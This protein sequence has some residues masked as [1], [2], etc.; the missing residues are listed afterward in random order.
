MPMTDRI[1]EEHFPI[2]EKL[3]Q[4]FFETQKLLTPRYICRN[5]T[6]VG[7][8]VYCDKAE[9][10]LNM[11][12]GHR[13][14]IERDGSYFNTLNVHRSPEKFLCYAYVLSFTKVLSPFVKYRSNAVVP[15]MI[16]YTF[17][18]DIMFNQFPSCKMYTFFI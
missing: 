8:N 17:L 2:L 13:F 6:H 7:C 4:L 3:S 9:A 15:L 1:Q 10:K 5:E 16:L 12:A 14:Y 18:T 11:R